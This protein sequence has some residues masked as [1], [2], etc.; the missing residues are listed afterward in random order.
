MG[1]KNEE[2]AESRAMLSTKLNRLV[3]LSLIG[4]EDTD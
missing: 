3:L 1:K 4:N 2:K